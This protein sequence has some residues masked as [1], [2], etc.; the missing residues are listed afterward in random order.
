MEKVILYSQTLDP[1]LVVSAL[2]RLEIKLVAHRS[3]LAEV[4]VHELDIL[5]VIIQVDTLDSE[6]ES[7]LS[8]LRRSMPRLSVAVI[9]ST[10][11]AALPEVF[12]HIDLNVPLTTLTQDIQNYVFGSAVTNR[13]RVHRFD[14]PLQGYLS[15]DGQHWVDYR[16]RSLSA[17]GA[18]LECETAFPEPGLKGQL[19]I[20]FQDFKMLTTCEIL[21]TRHGSSNLPAGFGV[22]FVGFSDT[23]RQVIDRIVSDALVD[24]LLRP[25][26][27]PTTPTLGPQDILSAGPE[28]M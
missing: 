23:S 17:H 14:W 7:L 5:C 22:R 11:R 27:E 9:C 25:A 8:S 6:F 12:T 2:A 4:I 20:V 19:R 16:V 3:E 10:C 1:S 21:D 18:F 24:T 28:L 26:T 15:L 13:R